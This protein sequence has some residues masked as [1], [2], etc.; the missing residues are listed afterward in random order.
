MNISLHL[1]LYEPWALASACRLNAF[2]IIINEKL[3]RHSRRQVL[4]IIVTCPLLNTKEGLQ[5][6]MNFGNVAVIV[7]GPSNDHINVD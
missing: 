7:G 6:F 1:L 3:C 4:M 5:L 2:K